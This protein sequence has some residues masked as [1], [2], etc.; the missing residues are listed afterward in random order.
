[1]L[2]RI[3]M[4]TK[5]HLPNIV[6]SWNYYERQHEWFRNHTRDKKGL[7]KSLG[8][9]ML[10]RSTRALQAVEIYSKQF[11]ARKVQSQVQAT[12]TAEGVKSGGTLKVIK[13]ET[14]EAFTTESQEVRDTVFALRDA[15]K[16]AMKVKKEEEPAEPTP[17]Q[18]AEYVSELS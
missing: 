18:Y 2:L 15:G 16:D 14:W 17:Q 8:V 12:V 5:M 7:G 11:Y 9:L 1:M 3:T 6:R 10:A 13:A 4:M